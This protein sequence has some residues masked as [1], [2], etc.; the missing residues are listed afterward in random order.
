MILLP[1]T[2]QEGG[3]EA[4]LAHELTHLKRRDTG[5]LLLL[6]CVRCIHWFNPLV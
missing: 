2:L 4:A 3:R 6:T 1:E 5:Y